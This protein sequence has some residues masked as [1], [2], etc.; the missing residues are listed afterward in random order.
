MYTELPKTSQG[1]ALVLSLKGEAQ[2]AALELPEDE[3]AQ[4][5]GVDAILR[6]LNRLFMKDSSINR[7]QALEAFE[8]FKRPSDMSIQ[9]FLYKF[10]KRLFKTTFYGS[11]MSEDVL[12]NLLNHHEQLIKATL[13]ELQ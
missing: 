10:E 7:Y 12:A 13:P 5:N 9:S 8:T 4:E 2:D 3:I 6:W 1:P 11:V